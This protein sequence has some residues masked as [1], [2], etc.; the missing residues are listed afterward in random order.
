MSPWT[1]PDVEGKVPNASSRSVDSTDQR[2]F[3]TP[4]SSLVEEKSDENIAKLLP[5]PDLIASAAEKAGLE[6]SSTQQNPANQALL[7]T[8]KG[9]YTLT[10]NF[11]FPALQNQ[12]EVIMQ[13]VAVGLNPIDWKSVDYGFCLPSFPWI[14]GREMAGVVHEVGSEVTGVKVGDLVW[15]SE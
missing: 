13:S 11:D 15:T 2:I 4:S 8:A 14:T 5:T 7:V 9:Q 10:H 3:D 12:R 6:K 1:P